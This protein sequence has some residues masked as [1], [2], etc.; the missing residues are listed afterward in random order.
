MAI[1]YV[2]R[3]NKVDTHKCLQTFLRCSPYASTLHGAF[4]N[5]WYGIGR[6]LCFCRLSFPPLPL[7][8]VCFVKFN[9]YYYHLCAVL[10]LTRVSQVVE[11][12]A[13]WLW[14]L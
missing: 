9:C 3:D 5:L 13:R 2:I 4:V 6:A 1:F 12:F 7:W 10:Y 14:A 8:V 11:R